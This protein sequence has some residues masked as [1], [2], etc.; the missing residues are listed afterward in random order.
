MGYHADHFSDAR[1]LVAKNY[2]MPVARFGGELANAYMSYSRVHCWYKGY[3]CDLAELE[4]LCT[5]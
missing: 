5:S 2:A 4:F 1:D 3:T